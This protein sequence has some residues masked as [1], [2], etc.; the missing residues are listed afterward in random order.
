VKQ[1]AWIRGGVEQPPQREGKEEEEVGE[2]GEAKEG[3]KR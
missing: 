1:K 2:A 3:V